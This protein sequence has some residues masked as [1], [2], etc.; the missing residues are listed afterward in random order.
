MFT[1][2]F[3]SIGRLFLPYLTEIV[4]MILGWE[5]SPKGHLAMLEV[6]LVITAE[7]APSI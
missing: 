3:V 7:D 5:F 4:K 6:I 1:E 2:L